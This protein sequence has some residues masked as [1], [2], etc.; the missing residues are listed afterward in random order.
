MPVKHTGKPGDVD[1]PI[2]ACNFTKKEKKKNIEKRKKNEKREKIEQIERKTDR[3][4]KESSRKEKGKD[5]RE[6]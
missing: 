6:S 2:V 4:Q 5:M 1:E 3:R